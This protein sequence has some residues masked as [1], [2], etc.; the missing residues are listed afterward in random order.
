MTGLTTLLAKITIIDFIPYYLAINL[1]ILSLQL[2]TIFITCIRLQTYII[3]EYEQ[4][5]KN[6][7]GGRFILWRHRCYPG[8]GGQSCPERIS[9]RNVKFFSD[10]KQ[11]PDLPCSV[12]IDFRVITAQISG[13]INESVYLQYNSGYCVVFRFTLFTHTCK[14]QDWNDHTNRRHAFDLSMDIVINTGIS[15]KNTI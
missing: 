7:S 9:G 10:R 12:F 8:S 6:K 14:Y 2:L 13:E 3:Y 15:N 4:N 11:I 5:R 1:F